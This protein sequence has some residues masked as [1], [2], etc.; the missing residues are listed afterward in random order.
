[1]DGEENAVTANK[2]NHREKGGLTL[3]GEYG[4]GNKSKQKTVAGRGKKFVKEGE[5][6]KR[7]S[8]A[9]S[10]TTCSPWGPPKNI[11]PGRMH[12]KGKKTRVSTGRKRPSGGKSKAPKNLYPPHA[13]RKTPG[14]ET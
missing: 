8:D 10:K 1:M 2:R 13:Q 14:T 7:T 6:E 11:V 5:G 12:G 3:R 9:N 4:G